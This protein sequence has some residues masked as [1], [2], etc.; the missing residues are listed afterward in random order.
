MG[1]SVDL[2]FPNGG[3]KRLQHTWHA[4]PGA[5][6]LKHTHLHAYL[7]LRAHVYL[8]LRWELR[9]LL[10]LRSYLY[11]RA[12]LRLRLGLHLARACSRL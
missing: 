8:H 2:L 3:T 11:L 5:D 1:L 7:R 4:C 12:H 9:V 6:E 10:Y